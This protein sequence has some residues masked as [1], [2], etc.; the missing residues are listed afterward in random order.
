M[1]PF[2]AI[3]WGKGLRG[4][5]KALW[6]LE[7]LFDNFLVSKLVTSLILTSGRTPGSQISTSKAPFLRKG[8]MLPIGEE[9]LNSRM[10]GPVS[11]KNF[12]FCNYVVL[13]QQKLSFNFLSL[14][15]S[16]EINSFGNGTK[17]ESSLW[18][19]T[20][21]CFLRMCK[22][23]KEVDFWGNFGISRFTSGSNFLCGDYCPMWFRLER[24]C[25]IELVKGNETVCGVKTNRKWPYTFLKTA[26]S[27]ED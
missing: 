22:V 21:S 16:I 11:G 26:T 19:V 27:L 3:R 12:N 4:F 2:L 14:E 6:K 1:R 20:I 7:N 8:Q 15:F 23:M 9:F 5:G 25:P 10:R 18:K 13:N 24:W 17:M